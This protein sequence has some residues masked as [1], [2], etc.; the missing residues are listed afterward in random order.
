[1]SS[2]NILQ[3]LN[4]ITQIVRND[5]LSFNNILEVCIALMKTAQTFNISGQE[6][7]KAVIEALTTYIKNNEGDILLLNTIPPFIDLVIS[8]SRGTVSLDEFVKVADSCF[9]LCCGKKK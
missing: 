4:A 9:S 6:K 8:I 2:E 3:L 1:M 5:S 7:K